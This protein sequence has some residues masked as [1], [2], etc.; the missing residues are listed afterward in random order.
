[1]NGLLSVGHIRGRGREP[2]KATHADN[3][4]P[5]CCLCQRTNEGR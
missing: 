5:Q 1:V 3:M 4:E 2:G